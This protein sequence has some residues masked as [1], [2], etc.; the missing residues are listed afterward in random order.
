MPVDSAPPCLHQPSGSR[1]PRWWARLSGR[2]AATSATSATRR[3]LLL[4]VVT[5]AAA[6]MAAGG[7]AEAA[8]QPAMTTSLAK[9]FGGSTFACRASEVG[10][11]MIPTP[12]ASWG[13]VD[14]TKFANDWVAVP[15]HGYGVERA[16]ADSDLAVQSGG[17]LNLIAKRGAD[18]SWRGPRYKTRKMY[19]FGTFSARLK[20]P[21]GQ[22]AWPAF[23]LVDAYQPTNVATTAEI[24]VMEAINSCNVLYSSVHN[25]TGAHWQNTT[26][27]A[28]A[29]PGSWHTYTVDWRADRIQF[30]LDRTVVRT[31]RPAD[32]PAWPFNTPMYVVLD[33]SVGG[34]WAKAPNA[35]TPAALPMAVDW[36][37]IYR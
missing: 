29:K 7:A 16:T 14:T 33:V 32:L 17:N 31:L 19:Q 5:V 11:R 4:P 22:G 37:R 18:G 13:F 34:T 6:L 28:I 35:T 30:S 27:A 12:V 26:K 20:L 9:G 15:G 23:W 2:K 21:S 10:C 36:L 25:W 1:T 3:R 24:D 8:G